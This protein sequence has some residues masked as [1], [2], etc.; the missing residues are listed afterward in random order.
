MKRLKFPENVKESGSQF[1]YDTPKKVG[2]TKR[3]RNIGEAGY[4]L[5]DL[6]SG[7]RMRHEHDHKKSAFSM[8]CLTLDTK[9]ERKKRKC[10]EINSSFLS[11]QKCTLAM[12]KPQVTQLTAISDKRSQHI[13]SKGALYSIPNKTDI[14][15][16]GRKA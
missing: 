13:S 4:A 8:I 15:I 7:G 16:A 9:G 10:Y 14:S 3:K 12:F 1:K 6:L 2:T 11:S 5:E